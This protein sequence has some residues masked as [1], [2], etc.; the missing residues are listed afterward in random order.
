M[1]QHL[2]EPAL[3]ILIVISLALA[4]AA[5]LLW[6]GLLLYRVM[7]NRQRRKREQTADRW[8]S[9]LLPAL[10]GGQSLNALPRLRGRLET[11]AVLGLLRD[12]AE[13]FRGQ[14]R[15]NLHAVLKHIGAEEYGFRLLKKSS[16]NFRMR[17]CALLAWMAPSARVDEKLAV[18]LRDPRPGVRLEA[19]HALAARSTPGISLQT[20]MTS[21]RGTEAMRSDRTR[22]I[23]R[24][25][26]PGQSPALGWLL[27]SAVDA[28]EKALLLDGL[29]VAGD[30]MYATQAA[31]YLSDASAKVRAAAVDALE[32]LADP[33]HI[34]AVGVLARDPDPR[35]RLSVAHYAR[36]MHGDNTATTVLEF[37]A[38]DRHFEVRRTAVHALAVWRGRSWDHLTALARQDPLL[39][40]IMREATQSNPPMTAATLVPA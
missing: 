9:L 33:L 15:D 25:M 27:Q 34:D 3:L 16:E 35:V 31:T 40:S 14:Y 39:E 17:G 32:R 12:L 24:L 22:D 28:R 5:V 36:T 30:F 19:A 4:A 8:L 26:A 23:I 21:L 2:M 18:L 10:E 1:M 29:A 7:D 37:L 13:R 6:L 11:E 38:M 20:I